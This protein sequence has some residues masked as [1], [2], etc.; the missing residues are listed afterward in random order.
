MSVNYISTLHSIT[1][2]LL[3]AFPLFVAQ[4]TRR[5]ANCLAYGSNLGG[6]VRGQIGNA[7]AGDAYLEG[8]G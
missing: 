1:L 3:L 6:I 5:K 2:V 7:E 8:L 4:Q